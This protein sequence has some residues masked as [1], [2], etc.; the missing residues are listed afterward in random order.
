MA[1]DAANRL[2]YYLLVPEQDKEHL[3][4]LRHWEHLKVAT[5]GEWIWVSQFREDE[6]GA[7]N[8]KSI[9]RKQLFYSK[10]G[11]LFPLNSLLPDRREPALLW[12]PIQRAFPLSIPALNHNYFGV[13]EELHPKII[14]GG[15]E[16]EAGALYCSL[17]KLEQIALQLPEFRL[18]PLQWTIINN[19]DALVF[20]KPLL[21]IEG[22]AFRI[23]GNFLFPAGFDLDLF[24][25]GDLLYKSIDPEQTSWI[26]WNE[27]SSYFRVEKSM[28]NPLTR[29]SL[30]KTIRSIRETTLL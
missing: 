9:P 4:E 13:S 2:I 22:K 19:M 8:V 7:V 12:T 28:L 21:P 6:L 27:D 20:G 30:Q 17:E 24:S 23:T 1:Q 26:V 11:K 29:S 18:E 25:V 3:A 10:A 15:E 5:E 16:K 14:T